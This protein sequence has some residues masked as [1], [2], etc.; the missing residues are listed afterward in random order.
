MGHFSALVLQS[1]P[2]EHG[3]PQRPSTVSGAQRENLPFASRTSAASVCR[4][5]GSRPSAGALPLALS[6]GGR[7]VPLTPSWP[8]VPA[9]AVGL[10]SPL[11]VGQVALCGSVSFTLLA[12]PS[13]EGTREPRTSKA[14][15]GASATGWQ[16]GVTI[17]AARRELARCECA[18]NRL[19]WLKHIQTAFRGAASAGV[20]LLRRAP[21]M[22][23]A[24]PS[25]HGGSQLGQGCA[26]A[27]RLVG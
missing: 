13:T 25:A 10:V 6:F 8:S 23:R 16:C 22:V 12:P 20:E 21:A 3:G 17:G 19:L 11:V 15:G 5:L 7:G 1:L 4:S 2:S 18:E 27:Q 24:M 9:L 26:G 14:A